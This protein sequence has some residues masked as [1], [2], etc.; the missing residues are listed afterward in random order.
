[1]IAINKLITQIQLLKIP[2]QFFM[3]INTYKSPV[4]PRPSIERNLD[5]SFYW[6]AKIFAF[7]IAGVLIWITIQVALQAVPA[8]QEFGLGFLTSSSWNPVKSEYGVLPAIYGTIVSSFIAL[9]ISVPIGLGVAIFLSEDY[10]PPA[11][12]RIIVF[13]VELLAAVPSVVYGLWG[14]FVLIPFLK[15]IS[16]LKGPGMLPAALILSVMILP[17]IAAISRDA[18]INVP[19]GLRQAAVGLGATR[20]EAIL[21]I[22]LPA[23][24]SGIIG[25][26]MLALGRALGETMAVTMLIGNSNKISPSV[27]APSNTVSSLLANQFAEASGLQVAALMYAALILFL[28]T[29]VVNIL[30]QVLVVRLQKI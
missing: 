17:T 10:F 25:G 27:F 9:L 22:V 16:P 2:N 29:L 26:I 28:I 6:S 3:A 20:W 13:L 5:R 8:V 21:Q 7:A 23:A 24:S 19:G 11:I 18:I 15:N 12:Q 30:A 4:A 1:L 14:I